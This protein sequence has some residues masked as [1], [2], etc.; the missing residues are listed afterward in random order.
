MGSAH[1]AFSYGEDF[2]EGVTIALREM[3][4]YDYKRIVMMQGL[5][6]TSTKFILKTSG[7][8]LS[9]IL[10][11]FFIWKVLNSKAKAVFF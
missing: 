9:N 5:I 11:N 2:H 10:L 4:G 6:K 7:W 1:P 3:K 8:R